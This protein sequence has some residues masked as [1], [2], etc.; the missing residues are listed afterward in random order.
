[1]TSESPST[2]FWRG[3]RVLVTGHTGFKGSWLS[4]WL[5]EMGAHVYGLSLPPESDRCFFRTTQLQTK[6]DST[7]GDIRDKSAVESVFTR[8]QPE[9]VF[10]LAAQA[11]VR[12]AYDDPAETYS[13]NLNGLTNVL[14]VAGSCETASAL[15]VATSDKV[16]ENRE[17]GRAFVESD[18]LGGVEPYGISKAAGEFLVEAFRYSLAG[19]PQLGVATV[20]A[21]NV[22]GGGDWA[23]DRL[24]PDAIKAFEK[25]APLAL[26]N[27][28]STRPW[29]HVVDPLA[30]YLLLAEKLASADPTWR[31]A[32]NF[33]P[34]GSSNEDAW[35]VRDIAN[36]LAAQWNAHGGRPTATWVDASDPNAPY[37]ATTLTVD[38]SKARSALGWSPRIPL[39]TAL[40]SS[41]KWYLRLA[42]GE[43]MSLV[44]RDTIAAAHPLS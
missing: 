20:R 22:I 36:V 35:P 34:L 32:W 23:D 24:V 18:A 19:N 5:S 44:A 3:K 27:P 9:I 1:M 38:S 15:I 42:A 2:A 8:T 4:F 28:G 41:V 31:T 37:E 30:G 40:E 6:I 13:T 21:G 10:H 12:R 33:G 17:D 29:Q 25:G 26:R 7:F 43:D 11:L 39:E 14:D 16:Y